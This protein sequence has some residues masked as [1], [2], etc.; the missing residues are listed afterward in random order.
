[1]KSL[2]NVVDKYKS[3]IL[4][5]ERYLWEHPET[6]YKEWKTSEYMA[7]NF[8]RLGYEIVQAEGITGFYTLIDTGRKGSEVLILA[9]LD[10]VLCP[11]HK[12]ADPKTG[13][14]HACG[15]H[16]QCATLL[17]LAAALTEAKIKEK[18]CGKIRLCAVPA[19][20]LLELEY[21]SA[22]KK[23][24]K[25]KYFSGK[26]EFLSR[27]YFDG[28]DLAFMVH[29]SPVFSINLGSVGSVV[30]NITFKGVSAHAGGRPWDGKNA[31][32]AATLGIN[33]VNALRETFQDSDLIRVHPIITRGG[34][35][36]NAIPDRVTMESYVR[37][38][39]FEAIKKTNQKIN[40][41]LCGA[42]LSLG[43]NIEINDIHGYAPLVNDPTLLDIAREAATSAIPEQQLYDLEIF[44][45]GSTD[46]GDLSCLMPVLHAYA[47]GSVGAEHGEDYQIQDPESACVG[48]AKWQLAILFLLLEKGAERAKRIIKKYKPPFSSKEA[49]LAYIDGI[50]CDCDRIQ[51]YKNGSAKVKLD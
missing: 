7:E 34:E 28:V 13:A 3:L 4:E 42:A 6:G 49:Y 30:K 26:C 29:A 33:A 31:L 19:E 12:N 24:G 47:G 45:A 15:H 38:K 35:A 43:T 8:I 2:L 23:Q 21:R 20:E 37:G 16:A 11:T 32:Y 9:E 36:V 46:M 18:L 50:N 39:S 5:T 22:L 41:A 1:M 17:G 27:G 44:T 10:A 40:Q 51:Y 48:N 25:I 14:V